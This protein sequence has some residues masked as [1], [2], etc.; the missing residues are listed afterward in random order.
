MNNTFCTIITSNFLH[1]AYA[2]NESLLR[3]DKNIALN[4]FVS[5]SKSNFSLPAHE[6]SNIRFY[7]PDEVC[8]KGVNKKIYDKYFATNKNYFRWSMKGG[9]ITY[10]MEEKAYEKV[11][12]VDG[13]IYFFNPYQFLFDALDTD[14]ILLTPHWRC[15]IEPSKDA[16]NFQ[17]LFNHGLYNA[18]FLG[19][20]KNGLPI[21]K[22]LSSWCLYNCE[23]N[24]IKGNYGDQTYLNLL[25][26]YFEKVKVLKHR[27]CNISSWNLIEC[28]RKKIDDEVLIN[29]IFKVIFIHFVKD[30]IWGIKNGTDLLLAPHLN[31]Y[32][33]SLEKYKPDFNAYEHFELGKLDR[34]IE[35][36]RKRSIIKNRI[37]KLEKRW[38]FKVPQSIINTVR[39][40]S[41][42]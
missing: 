37:K 15:A 10:L 9:F 38:N 21:L 7:F 39:K 30:Q 3:Y 16:Q 18:G 1:F 17:H 6:F 2:L 24:P 20:N 22:Q 14:S 42:R 11:I 25:P 29:G 12:F 40:I 41:N 32:C 23:I 28:E 35:R 5:E 26:V 33:K 4:V 34:L 19:A 27:G 36:T 8:N 31:A 13:D